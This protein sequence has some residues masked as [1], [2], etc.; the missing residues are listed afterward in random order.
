MTTGI[1]I[2]KNVGNNTF[3]EALFKLIGRIAGILVRA[4]EIK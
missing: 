3:G 2:P 4:R 1:S